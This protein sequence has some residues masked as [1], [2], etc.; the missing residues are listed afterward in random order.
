MATEEQLAIALR[1]AHKAGDTVAAQKLA[2][3]IQSMRSQAPQQ[4]KQ[5]DK[6]DRR[7]G[8][9]SDIDTSKPA[10]E[11]VKKMIN[12]KYQG[13][14]ALGHHMGNLPLSLGQA[15]ANLGG[16]VGDKL[17]IDSLRQNA[18][19]YNEFMR[20]REQQ[21][22]AET[23]DSVASY[24]GATVGEI[25]PWMLGA[26]AKAMQ[27][28]AAPAKLIPQIQNATGIGQRVLASLSRNAQRAVGGAGQ[29]TLAALLTP[30]TSGDYSNKG[31]Q[32]AIGAI[33]GGALP[34]AV[35][36]GLS[37]VRGSKLAWEN[38]LGNLLDSSADKKAAELIR[39]ASLRPDSLMRPQ[40]S[41]VPG[42]QRTLA[43]E[44][45][46]EGI[47]GLQNIFKNPGADDIRRDV[48]NTSRNMYLEDITGGSGS[49]YDD[50]IQARINNNAGSFDEARNVQFAVPKQAEKPLIQMPKGVPYPNA[51]QSQTADDIKPLLESLEGI[52]AGFKGSESERVVQGYIN[53]IKAAKGNGLILDNIR[54]DINNAM[55][56]KGG[57]VNIRHLAMVKDAFTGFLKQKS[58][59][60][61]K[62][63]TG[64]AKDSVPISRMDIGKAIVAPS[65]K[66][67]AQDR[68]GY[69]VLKPQQ[70]KG[71]MDNLDTVAQR[72]TGFNRAKASDYLTPED[73]K[74]LGNVSD[75]LER[76]RFA[77][78]KG[79][80]FGSPT[81][82]RIQANKQLENT[83]LSKI[84]VVGKAFKWLDDIGQEK[85]KTKLSEVLINP[86]QARAILA[87]YP[88]NE[89]L[90]I[91]NAIRSMGWQGVLLGGGV[92]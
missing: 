64:W 56:N 84:P 12:E 11:N 45:Q 91:E 15:T 4:P 43:E 72:A 10:S 78:T 8:F 32:V 86:Q 48:N 24:A 27:Y 81:A 55:S 71:R 36:A 61:N 49:A 41:Q 29:G 65:S 85:L 74:K 90:V 67:A 23:P 14:G 35:T 7:Q 38:T 1:N 34:L 21:Y 6:V 37:G 54:D 26:P 22:Q 17:G 82:Q 20:D 92:R 28:A 53:R 60:F 66:G 5:P 80:L 75:D 76:Q 88:A 47:A 68:V 16:Y 57:D 33:S 63:L 62:A 73:M 2:N 31:N 83:V 19:S 50:A 13:Y 89:R 87:S 30:E 44:T 59:E 40:P 9:I 18:D 3:A 69:E 42:V 77:D 46:D 70:F 25:V 52:K 51:P 79:A 58:P 39:K